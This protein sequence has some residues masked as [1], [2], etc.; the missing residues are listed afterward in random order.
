MRHLDPMDAVLQSTTAQL[1]L[2]KSVS[3][4]KTTKPTQH[5]F[6]LPPPPPPPP[7]APPQ[8]L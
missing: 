1:S 7:P 4:P 2:G 5:P 6:P 3:R 8:P